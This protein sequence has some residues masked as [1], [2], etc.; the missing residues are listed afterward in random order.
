VNVWNVAR[1]SGASWLPLGGGLD[2]FVDALLPFDDGSG[3]ALYV[4][5]RF[6]STGAGAGPANGI[7]RWSGASWTPLGGSLPADTTVDELVVFDDGTGSAV[8]A[9]KS[10]PGGVV[11][12]N[13]ASW[14]PIGSYLNC[15]VADFEVFDDGS[16]PA[17]YAAGFFR[18]P[19]G[20]QHDV[21]RW[22]G[23]SWIGLG[24]E[25]TGP[26]S[27]S[28]YA[29]ATFDDGT[30]PA[31]IV[32][33]YFTHSGATVVNCVARWN[34]SA[35]LPLGTGFHHVSGAYVLTLTTFDSGTGPRL[36]A[37]GLFTS[38]GGNTAHHVA[39]WNGSTWSHVGD[40]TNGVVREL[41]VLDDGDGPAL[42]A[43]G[44]FWAAGGV[45]T[46]TL[47]KWNGLNWGP[48]ID[49]PQ[50]VNTVAAFDDGTG[51][52]IYLG[53]AF[54]ASAAGDSFL[55]KWT[56]PCAWGSPFCFGDG[57]G[58]PCP[59]ANFSTPGADEGCLHSFGIGGKLVASGVARIT[60]DTFVLSG[61][62]MPNSSALYFQG[63]SFPG[64]GAGTVFGDGLR[65]ATG[66]VTRLGTK[67][68]TGGASQYPA[69]GDTRISVAGQITAPTTRMYQVWYRNSANFCTP[70][71]FNLT[72][73]WRT[74]WSL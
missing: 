34:G 50:D 53:G 69:A 45:L 71:G 58:T 12:W 18:L 36:F 72:N 8:Y 20:A 48:F 21:V 29:L 65:C 13:G 39:S 61:S 52:A 22:N 70:S 33:G 68:N 24:P 57:S 67:P 49:G 62:R 10:S 1:Q 14:T 28:A 66:L 37:G 25:F 56:P 41:N 47:A 51:T 60:A 5:G 23:T 42:I 30:G 26:P 17:L 3:P 74:F 6:T 43:V 73:G 31:L 4:G 54:A 38:A 46:G 2:S 9:G 7:A 64:S 27:A 44:G 16:G 55:A 32:G 19:G 35:W 63:T 11:R 59:C 15:S 40:G